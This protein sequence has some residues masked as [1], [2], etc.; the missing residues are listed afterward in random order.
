MAKSSTEHEDLGGLDAGPSVDGRAAL[1]K[2][3]EVFGGRIM[4]RP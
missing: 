3:G 1:S 2:G 4:Q